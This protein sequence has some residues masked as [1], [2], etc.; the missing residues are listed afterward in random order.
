LKDNDEDVREA[1][2]FALGEIGPDAKAAVPVLSKALRDGDEGVREAAA[3]ALEKI[4]P[5]E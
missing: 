4:Q 3:D 2:A 1:A 5:K